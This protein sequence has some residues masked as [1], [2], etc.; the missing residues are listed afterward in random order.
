MEA[1]NGLN[2][3]LNVITKETGAINRFALYDNQ[4]IITT[5]TAINFS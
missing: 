1:Y 2:E 4:H 5:V 3:L